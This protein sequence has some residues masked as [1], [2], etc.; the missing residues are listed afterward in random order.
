MAYHIKCLK[1]C[2][3][4]TYATNIIELLQSRDERGFFQCA[5]RK[6]CGYI[7]R[8]F[9]LQE[10]GEFWEPYLRGAI[11]LGEEGATYQP[12]IYLVSYSPD[13][14]IADLWFSYFK[15]TRES[16][17]RLKLGHGP[18]GPPVLSMNQLVSLL[19]RLVS[20]GA[21]SKEHIQARLFGSTHHGL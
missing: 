10:K 16:G 2:E 15:D 9:E 8:R 18:G 14:P 7:E 6:A 20:I 11:A 3:D 13:G 17:G 5:C 12:F 19:G 21:L 4:T 1:G